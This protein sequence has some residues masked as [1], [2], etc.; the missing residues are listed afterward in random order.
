MLRRKGR[1][2]ISETG[3]NPSKGSCDFAC[4]CLGSCVFFNQG[5]RHHNHSSSFLYCPLI[6]NDLLCSLS[7]FFN[8]LSLY[9]G[10]DSSMTCDLQPSFPLILPKSDVSMAAVTVFFIPSVHVAFYML[11]SRTYPLNYNNNLIIIH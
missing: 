9:T 11:Y 1:T 10:H 7:I 2:G 5:R 8:C 4:T 6:S 3:H